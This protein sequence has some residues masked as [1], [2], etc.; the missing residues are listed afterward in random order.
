MGKLLLTGRLLRVVTALLAAL[1]FLTESDPTVSASATNVDL[2]TILIDVNTDPGIGV[3]STT[4]V[5]GGLVLV[6]YKVNNLG[7]PASSAGNVGF[8]LSKQPTLTPSAIFL[9]YADLFEA[10]PASGSTQNIFGN[11][12]L[13]TT[14]PT[15]MYYII[16]VANYDHKVL[17]TNYSN[18]PSNALAITVTSGAR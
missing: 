10:V 2:T 14:L 1:V 9:V 11:I 17:E 7:S 8:Y 16:V 12:N 4:T 6:E 3:H 13:P 15:G 18:N 5:P